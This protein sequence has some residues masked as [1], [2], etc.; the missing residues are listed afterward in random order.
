[1]QR[2]RVLRDTH[3]KF[4]EK[5]GLEGKTSR[6][7]KRGW[8]ESILG[9]KGV[10]GEE[11]SKAHF[12]NK[13]KGRNSMLIC[14]K[15]EGGKVGERNRIERLLHLAQ[16]NFCGIR[17]KNSKRGRGNIR[18]YSSRPSLLLEGKRHLGVPS[19][20]RASESRI[21]QSEK[22]IKG[23]RAAEK[24]ELPLNMLQKRNK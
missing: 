9:E 22:G 1:M 19:L 21:D 13:H 3:G 20:F 5:R 10:S 12:F 11:Q 15:I 4:D 24:G 7:E 6:K 18:T 8:G 23:C 16:E 2:L 17:E 14:S